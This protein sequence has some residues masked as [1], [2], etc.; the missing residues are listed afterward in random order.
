MNNAILSVKRNKNIRMA[1]LFSAFMFVQ[2]IILRMGNQAGRGFLAEQHQELVYLFIQI[3]VICGFFSHALIKPRLLSEKIKNGLTVSSLALCMSGALVMLFSPADS[4]LYLVTTGL[5]VFFLGCT[6]GAVYY[7]LAALTAKKTRAG[8]CIG[9][10]YAA[11]VALQFCLQLQ[12]TV[13][14]ALSVLLAAAF[15]VMGFLLIKSKETSYY[16]GSADFYNLL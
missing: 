7:R 5:T 1:V 3:V 2:F 8:L 6:G 9:T 16:H 12:W 15:A 10:G 11:A 4:L 14:P 13:I